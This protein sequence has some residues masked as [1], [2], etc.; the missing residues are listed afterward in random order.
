MNF[1]NTASE[2]SESK[3]KIV[4]FNFIVLNNLL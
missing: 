3:F 4:A 1:M 2:I